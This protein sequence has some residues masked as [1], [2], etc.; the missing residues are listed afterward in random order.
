MPD[1]PRRPCTSPGCMNL[2]PC[3]ILA[4]HRKQ[5]ASWTPD[6]WYL[7]RQWRVLRRQVLKR[8][9]YSCQICGRYGEAVD[10]IVPKS[11]G[12]ERDN[13]ANLQTLCAAHHR[14]KTAQ[15]GRAR[16]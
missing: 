10:H 9:R 5:W 2:Q 14:A 4:H 12:G 3:P 8:D 1:G 13:I 7:S 15:E 16:R 6:P 11:R